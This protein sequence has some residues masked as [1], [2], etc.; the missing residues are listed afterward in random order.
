MNTISHNVCYFPAQLARNKANEKRE[1][2]A[3]LDEVN[4]GFGMPSINIK[5]DVTKKEV[6]DLLTEALFEVDIGF[7]NIDDYFRMM[8]NPRVKLHKIRIF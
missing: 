8:E 5:E 1:Y 2:F 6:R 7:D 3:K 4:C